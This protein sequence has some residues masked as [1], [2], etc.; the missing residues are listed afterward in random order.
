MSSLVTGMA[1]H[2]DVHNQVDYFHNMNS[3]WLWHEAPRF[4]S[5]VCDE[6][7][8]FSVKWY[9]ILYELQ[10]VIYCNEMVKA[11][12]GSYVGAVVAGYTISQIEP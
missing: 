10:A 8:A 1:K 9:I 2:W 4:C 5:R 7:N 6:I 12:G 3:N 11:V